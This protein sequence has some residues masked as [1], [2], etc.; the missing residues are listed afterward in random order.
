MRES[1]QSIR[2]CINN[3]QIQNVYLKNKTDMWHDKLN[4]RYL[5]AS[6]VPAMRLD[7]H[8]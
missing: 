5:H 4:V 3:S 8:T 2:I 1:V 7:L 6:H